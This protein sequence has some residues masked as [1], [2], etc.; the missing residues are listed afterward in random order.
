MADRRI[1]GWIPTLKRAVT[2][3]GADIVVDGAKVSP[4]TEF[5]DHDLG[6]GPRSTERTSRGR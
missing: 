4:S 2:R 5:S 1:A 3:L 6:L